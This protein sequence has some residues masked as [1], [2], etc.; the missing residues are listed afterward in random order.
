MFLLLVWVG[1]AVGV[2]FLCSLLEAVLLSVRRT[3][4]LEARK[5]GS[6]GATLLYELKTAR[7]DDSIAAILTL[8]TISHTI[9]AALAGAQAAHVAHDWGWGAHET[10]AVGIFSAILTLLILVLS[11]IVPKTLG[12]VYAVQLAAPVGHVLRVLVAVSAPVL[13]VSRAL[14]RF[15]TRRERTRLS[16]GEVRSFLSVARG[17]GALA[18]DEER[19]LSNLLRLK[20]I[21]VSD[22]LTPRTVVQMFSEDATASEMI[23]ARDAD[24][25]SRLPL[26]GQSRDQVTGYVYQRDV[27]RAVARGAP[28]DTPLRLFQRPVHFV[29]E[30]ATVRAVL[31]DLLQRN[32][33]F[34]MA[35]DE[36]DGVA[37]VVSLEDLT[38]TLLGT[39]LVDEADHDADLREVALKLR[40]ERL[41]RA[42]IEPD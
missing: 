31:R 34:A 9:G 14:T 10:L 28:L 42:R 25:F 30:T 16:R 17:E 15:I 19:W 8:N 23:A 32:A 38:E 24:P 1:V 37:G 26:F 36:H 6:R 5:K 3:S 21:H 18:A 39:E 22:V 33:H 4:L 2:S 13:V 12:A 7:L 20:E 29:P 35:V 27:L 40:D 41:K 11:E